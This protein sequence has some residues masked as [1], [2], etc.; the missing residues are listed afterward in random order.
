MMNTK[1][2]NFLFDVHENQLAFQGILLSFFQ[3]V[4]CH[5]R[6]N[7]FSAFDFGNARIRGPVCILV[8]KP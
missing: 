8:F 5:V 4:F 6:C 2:R 3:H 1:A 7:D